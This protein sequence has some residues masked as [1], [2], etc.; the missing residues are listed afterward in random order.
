VTEIER[1]RRAVALLDRLESVLGEVPWDEDDSAAD[2]VR[3]AERQGMVLWHEAITEVMRGRI[4]R[5]LRFAEKEMGRR[6]P[7]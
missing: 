4:E 1:L 2:D 6:W 7:A 3:H 5:R